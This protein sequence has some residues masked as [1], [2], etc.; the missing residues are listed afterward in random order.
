MVA[1]V[2]QWRQW[3]AEAIV[4]LLESDGAATQRGMEAKIADV[5]YPGQ[6][7]PINPHHLTSARKRL[8]DADVIEETRERTRGGGVVPVFTLS[9]PTKAAQ[10]AAGRKRLL[11]TRFLGWS[12]ENTE[13]GAPPIPAALERVIHA[14]LRE[15]APYGY[16]MLRPDGGGEVRKIAGKPVAGG[17]LDNAAFYTGIGADGLPSPAILTTIEAKNLRQWIYPNSDE[18]YQLLDKSARLRLAHP[19][20]RIMPV[21]VCRRS[22]HNLG[23]MSAQ[24]GFHLIYTGTQY[25]RPAVA[26]TPDDERKFTEVN[27][28]LAYRLTLNEDSTPQ[29]VRQFTKSIPG[30]ID[31]AADRWTQFCSHPQVPDLL[32]SLRDPKLEYEDRQEFLGELADATEDVFAEDCEW[33]HEHPEDADGEDENVPF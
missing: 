21:F 6:R 19:Q 14:S 12:K 3:A 4:A 23:K 8:L 2:E 30:R 22:H 32:R 17:P 18:P 7:Y 9:S 5:K 10:R 1:S 11:H 26:A 13:W 15:A 27:T 16:H 20:L 29:M 24:L 33:R 28:E 31:E 25:V